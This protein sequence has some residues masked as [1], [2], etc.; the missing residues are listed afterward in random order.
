MICAGHGMDI[1]CQ[2]R[3][4]VHCTLVGRPSGRTDCSIVL[5]GK[6]YDLWLC[7]LFMT[8]GVTVMWLGWSGDTVGQ[9]AG[10]G[11][12]LASKDY[13]YPQPGLAR[14]QAVRS[15]HD[16][17]PPGPL[18]PSL[19]LSFIASNISAKY[20]TLFKKENNHKRIFSIFKLTFYFCFQMYH[21]SRLQYISPQ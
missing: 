1:F 5:V 2:V 12:Y 20:Q 17:T 21:N 19:C 10:P 6:C 3:C 15:H 7:V 18:Q 11:L 4:L 13:K 9:S 14:P 16:A 8:S